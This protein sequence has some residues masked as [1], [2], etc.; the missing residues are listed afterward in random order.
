MKKVSL[1]L[2]LVLSLFI[3][4]CDNASNEDASGLLAGI[5]ADDDSGASTGDPAEPIVLTDEQN[6]ANAA[7]TLA[8][9]NNG[10][11]NIDYENLFKDALAKIFNPSQLQTI[12]WN[13]LFSS[14]NGLDYAIPL[15]TVYNQ[16][17]MKIDACL[18]VGLTDGIGIGLTF[19]LDDYQL[20]TG[21]EPLPTVSGQIVVG[22]T[23][24]FDWESIFTQTPS[25]VMVTM[26]TPLDNQL[27][28]TGGIMNGQ[29]I[30]LVDVELE[31]SM[32][33]FNIGSPLSMSG[34]FI[35]NGVTV[36][37]DSKYIDLLIGLM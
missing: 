33:S 12:D 18:I 7:A 16:D 10:L 14:S 22:M 27:V 32:G 31:Y 5:T 25:A 20:Q 3:F 9:V 29:K 17:G 19:T 36:P 34:D 37:F 8:I 35:L 21:E 13:S 23:C 24:L 15:G 30:G 28:Y 2:V 26:D 1:F 11:Q 6:E 4:S